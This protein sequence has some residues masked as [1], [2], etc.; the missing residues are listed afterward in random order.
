MIIYLRIRVVY[1]RSARV[2]E[3]VL[4]Y[5]TFRVV[6][7]KYVGSLKNYECLLNASLFV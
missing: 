5:V 1:L 7:L 4:V 3:S 2:L 6:F